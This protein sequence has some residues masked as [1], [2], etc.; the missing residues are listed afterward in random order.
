MVL[1]KMQNSR[2]QAVISEIDEVLNKPSTEISHKITEEILIKSQQ[3]L[4]ETLEYLNQDLDKSSNL[5]PIDPCL[6]SED[7]INLQIKQS[8]QKVFFAPIKQYLQEDFAILQEEKQALQEEIRQLQKQRQENYSLAQQYAKQE[9]IIFE[10]SQVLLSQIQEIFSEHLPNLANQDLSPAQSVLSSKQHIFPQTMKD[11]E[12]SEAMQISEDK[13]E[14][15][16]KYDQSFIDYS[17]YDDSE[18]KNKIRANYIEADINAHNIQIKQLSSEI[19]ESNEQIGESVLPYP[20]YEFLERADMK[21]IT[22]E[23]EKKSL[24]LETLDN[25]E[26]FFDYQFSIDENQG[27][28][29]PKGYQQENENFA[30]VEPPCFKDNYTEN[31]NHQNQFLKIED[32]AAITPELKLEPSENREYLDNTEILE[33]LSNL[34][35]KLE[36]DKE[37]TNQSIDTTE[38]QQNITNLTNKL[39]EEKYTHASLT[40]N[41]LPIEELEKKPKEFLLSSKTLQCLRSDLESLEEIAVDEL[42]NDFGQT[43]LQLGEEENEDLKENTSVMTSEE[44]LTN[45][46]NL[47]VNINDVSEKLIAS[48]QKNISSLEDILDDL[49]PETDEEIIETD[50]QEFLSLE[51]LIQDKTN[52][53]KKIDLMRNG[54]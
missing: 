37:K 23:I 2:I 54:S 17:N 38:K 22:T 53:E 18:K 45:L 24:Q 10:F 1:L 27:L 40:Q 15:A 5:Q 41:L 49:R 9:K 7:T 51:T 12:T 31:Q 16:S 28:E 43:Q 19:D 3:V 36:S 35:G 6:P 30:E 33:S 29:I 11:I 39:E 42:I 32:E 48:N 14:E 50:N 44:E 52:L 47:F 4:H 34:F 13:L 46:E 25:Q 26:Y 8:L 20:G 21:S